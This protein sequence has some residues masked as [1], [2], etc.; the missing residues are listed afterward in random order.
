MYYLIVNW[1]MICI[2]LFFVYSLRVKKDSTS[3][4]K[5]GISI[6]I[7]TMLIQRHRLNDYQK[8]KQC[9]INILK[10]YNSKWQ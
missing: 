1:P 2:W 5:I 3:S 10:S 8:Y 7:Y 4:I 9:C 6:L